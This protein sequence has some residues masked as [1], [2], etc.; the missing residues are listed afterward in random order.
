MIGLVSVAVCMPRH[1]KMGECIVYLGKKVVLV[2]P[3]FTYRFL[4]YIHCKN[5]RL[6]FFV[7]GRRRALCFSKFNKHQLELMNA[8]INV[9][10]YGSRQDLYAKWYS[11]V[12]RTLGRDRMVDLHVEHLLLESLVNARWL[13][14]GHNVYVSDVTAFTRKYVDCSKHCEKE[15]FVLVIDVINRSVWFVGKNKIIARIPKSLCALETL[16]TVL[17]S[18]IFLVSTLRSY[19]L[20]SIFHHKIISASVDPDLLK[21]DKLCP[22]LNKLDCCINTSIE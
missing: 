11:K 22:Y 19:C 8:L 10:K 7:D 2:L 6:V 1:E 20:R 3:Y 15:S 13:S 14:L 5:R 18:S 16:L 9:K 4:Y 17:S 21:L 12:C